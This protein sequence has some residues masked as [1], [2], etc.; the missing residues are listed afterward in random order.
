MVPVTTDLAT[1]LK[2]CRLLYF[3]PARTG[4]RE[5]LQI[6]HRSIPPEHRLALASGDPERE[7]AFRVQHEARGNW[8]VLV[9]SV[10]AGSEHPRRAGLDGLPPFDGIVLVVASAA[11]ELDRSLAALEALKAYLDSWGLDLMGV[12]IV[13]QY[14]G[15][16]HAEALPVDRLESLLNP[17]GLLSFP[18]STRRGEGVRETL[19]SA[20]GLTINHLIQNPRPEPVSAQPRVLEPGVAETA[21]DRIIEVDTSSLGLEYGPPLPGTELAPADK[22]RGEEIFSELSP[23]VVIPV[24][25]PRSLLRG[26]VPLRLMLEITLDDD[27]S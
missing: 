24:R 6:L 26:D 19:K 22:R 7:I 21:A 16:D 20:L 12:P 27:T 18:A 2:T 5:N 11:A 4:K 23:P 25:I 8:Q 15:R 9:R 3:G 13:L 1:G 17:W 10:D 14:N